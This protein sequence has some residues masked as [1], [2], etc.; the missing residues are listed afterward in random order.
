[1]PQ[2]TLRTY[3][4]KYF[5]INMKIINTTYKLWYENMCSTI[6]IDNDIILEGA[7]HQQLHRDPGVPH[8]PRDCPRAPHGCQLPWLL[9]LWLQLSWLS[10]HVNAALIHIFFW[11]TNSQAE[12]LILASIIS[13]VSSIQR[14]ASHTRLVINNLFPVCKSFNS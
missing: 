7:L 12:Q 8:S 1:M 2:L 14:T 10:I 5:A 11:R 3:R 9:N 6:I 4:Y 13:F